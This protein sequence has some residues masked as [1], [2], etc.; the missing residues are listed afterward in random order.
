MLLAAVNIA[1]EHI[2]A[3]GTALKLYNRAAVHVL[4]PHT[5]A[6]LAKRG[7]A[8][9]RTKVFKSDVVKPNL[10]RTLVVI[11]DNNG[12][13]AVIAVNAV[14]ADVAELV[15][16]T[17]EQSAPEKPLIAVILCM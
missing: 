1:Y 6:A 8:F 13:M 16:F 3:T 17:R 14:N 9:A 7:V 2:S 12:I 15:S 4:L 5:E 10:A 11:G